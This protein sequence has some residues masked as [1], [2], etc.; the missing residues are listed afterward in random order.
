MIFIDFLVTFDKVK[1]KIFFSRK[2]FERTSNCRHLEDPRFLTE[3]SPSHEMEKQVPKLNIRPPPKKKNHQSMVFVCVWGG[4]ENVL[5]DIDFSQ[6]EIH[7]VFQIFLLNL[8][9]SMPTYMNFPEL[10]KTNFSKMVNSKKKN[11]RQ[12]YPPPPVFCTKNL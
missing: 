8:M 2:L 6:L 12:K 11:F 10:G 7:F 9:F 4:G 3:N 5:L 1:I